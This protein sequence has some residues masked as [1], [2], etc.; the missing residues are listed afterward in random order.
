MLASGRNG[1]RL[2]RLAAS[3]E[4]A[5][6]TVQGDVT[7]EADRA[8]LIARADA[9]GGA[10]VLVNNAG[11]GWM[12]IVERMPADDVR[13]LFETNV[14][15]LID[16]TQ[17]VLPGMLDRHRGHIVNVASGAS[18]VAFPPYSVYAAT[19]WAVQGFTEGLRREVI[20]RGVTA[21]T[22][23]P[24]P[25]AT[26][27]FARA[28]GATGGDGPPTVG[29]GTSL[30]A[31][32]VTRSIRLRHVPGYQ[33]IAVPAR[34]GPVAPRRG[35]RRGQDRRRR[36]VAES[37]ARSLTPTGTFHPPVTGSRRN[38]RLRDT[39][40]PYGHG[41]ASFP[42]LVRSLGNAGAVAN[43]Y[44]ACEERKLVEA[45]ID[46]LALRLTPTADGRGAAVRGRAAA[47]AA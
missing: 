34:R 44:R 24:G 16:L 10:D 13:T 1:D 41:M 46:A 28:A 35:A 19:K 36:H 20:G 30:V 5:I 33:V 3:G 31:R 14:L 4:G 7:V 25:I 47:G 32:A 9:L 45:R 6:E 42:R 15:A 27:F 21:A 40:G 12:G 39:F 37:P 29:P 17:K 18:W 11:L 2:D 23:N 26:E 8:A 43:A 22:I 38:G